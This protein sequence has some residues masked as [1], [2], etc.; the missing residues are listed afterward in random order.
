MTLYRVQDAEGRGPFRP[1]FSRSWRDE[2]GPSLPPI[3]DEL[4]IAF[5]KLRTLVPFGMAAGCACRSMEELRR[6]FSRAELRRL[7]RHGYSVVA[8]E[9]DHIL[10]ETPTQVLFAMRAPL[11]LLRRAA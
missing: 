10:A 2:H 5:D 7:A 6:W 11:S 1:G 3:Y 9:P 8:F 4:G